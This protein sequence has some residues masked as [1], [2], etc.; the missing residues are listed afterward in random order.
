MEKNS[1]SKIRFPEKFI[2]GTATSAYQ[3]EGAWN[4]DGKGESIWDRFSHTPGN[5]HQNETGDIAC[6][7]YHRWQDDLELLKTLEIGAYRFSIAWTRILPEGTGPVNQAGLDFY[8]KLV[9]G[10][11]Q[12]GITPFITLYHWDLPQALEDKGGWPSREIVGAFEAY[13]EI[14]VK[15]LGD[16]VKHWITHNEP[17]T[18]AFL[19]YEWGVFAPGRKDWN[20]ALRSVHHF[21]LSH[22]RAL[23]IIRDYCPGAEAGISL[24]L[25][26]VQP[27]SQN[28]GDLQA[29]ARLD[30][31][32]NRWFMDPLHGRGYPA[33]M[34]NYYFQRGYLASTHPDFVEENDLEEIAI[35]ADFLGISY[36]TRALVE[37][38]GEELPSINSFAPGSEKTETGWE[39][40]PEGLCQLLQHLEKEYKISKLYIYENGA[41]YSDGPGEDGEISDQRRVDYLKAHI[42]AARDAIRLGVP[43]AGYFVWSLMDNFEW[44]SGF[45]QRF[46]IVWTDF[47][48]QNRVPKMSALWYRDVIRQSGWDED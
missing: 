44:A 22:G 48:T 30:G 42:R 14:V 10:L 40:Y 1:G 8:S 11:L 7:H 38:K 31:H 41:S 43:L 17:W 21:L 12:R 16:R 13:T 47:S 20:S 18:A 28:Q 39:I 6:D 33:D 37:G 46:G 4:E 29:T 23:P 27:A 34:M 2:W 45:S 15:H 5:I 25:T 24:N 36:Y 35:P 32:I 3:I 19:G 9:D 26:D